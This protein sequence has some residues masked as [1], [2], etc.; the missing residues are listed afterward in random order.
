MKKYALLFLLLLFAL[1]TYAQDA[2]LDGEYG[3]RNDIFG[4]PSF[5]LT[6]INEELALLA[7]GRFGWIINHNYV[8][9]AEGYWLTNDVP[10][11]M[12]ASG[13]KPDLAIAF[14]GV[15]LEYLVHPYD[16]VH[17]SLSNLVGVGSVKY[18]YSTA[19]DDD[20]Y[21]V[22]EPMLNV[23]F[24]MTQYF[25]IGVGVGYRYASDVDLEELEDENLGGI[26]GKISLNFGTYGKTLIE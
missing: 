7:G 23:Y 21:W 5:E 11:P 10:G 8:I 19:R 9:G 2:P 16:M 18:D 13:Q 14:G 25:K 20:T 22:V 17:F 6:Q 15:T 12:T 3:T 4:A 26:V 1:P 24:R